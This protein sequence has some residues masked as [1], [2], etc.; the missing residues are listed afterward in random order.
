MEDAEY[1]A[2]QTKIGILIP[3]VRD[4]PL[5]E[6]LGWI[7]RAET[8]GPILHPTL[9]RQAMHNLETIKGLARALLPFQEEVNKLPAP[10]DD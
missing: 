9:Y 3:L 7:N 2:T 5:R 6:F 1:L 8:V 10:G 4:L